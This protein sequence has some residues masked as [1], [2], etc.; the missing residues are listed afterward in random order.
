MKGFVKASQE[1]GVFEAIQRGYLAQ[2][3]ICIF[4]NEN[5][6]TKLLEMYCFHLVYSESTQDGSSV[7]DLQIEDS[8]TRRIV[9]LKDIRGALNSVVRNMVSLNGTMP[10]LP[11]R[12]YM[13]FY[14]VW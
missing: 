13:S 5:E 2:L 10:H 3:Q 1:T 7:V 12:C 4:A 11:E 14:L 9:S 6:P 8:Q